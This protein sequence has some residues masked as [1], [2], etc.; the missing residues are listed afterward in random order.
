M[1]ILWGI[2]GAGHRLRKTLGIF[3]ELVREGHTLTVI[4][5]RAGEELSRIYGVKERLPEIAREVFSDNPTGQPIAGRIMMGRYDVYVIAPA[6]GNTV[7]KI[8]FGIAD[9]MVTTAFAMAQKT[10]IPIIVMPTEIRETLTELPCTVEK[11]L[12]TGCG[13]CLYVC[14]VDAIFL[15]DGIAHINLDLCNGCSLCPSVCPYGAISCWSLKLVKPRKVDLENINTL[16][17]MENTYVVMEPE[18]IPI[19]LRKMRSQ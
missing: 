16:K 17:N 2:T 4:M 3:E 12:C 10:G 14:P 9:T 19:L 1:R 18:E 11:N 13:E 8:V 5:S 6:T 15:E 7:S